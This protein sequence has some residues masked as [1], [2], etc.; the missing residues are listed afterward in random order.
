[1][2]VRISFLLVDGD[3]VLELVGARFQSDGSTS[4]RTSLHLILTF[5]KVLT[6]DPT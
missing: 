6:F 1:M 3:L 2:I 4:V 5:G